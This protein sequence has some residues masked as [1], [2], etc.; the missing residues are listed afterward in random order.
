ME[1]QF[2]TDPTLARDLDEHDE[3]ALFRERFVVSDP[4]TIYLDG[5][6]LGRLP[7]DTPA[8]MQDVI[9]KQWGEHL[10]RS[11]LLA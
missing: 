2:S 4:D 6:S 9:E 10:I 5:N 1:I 11:P 8:L 7:V 3:L